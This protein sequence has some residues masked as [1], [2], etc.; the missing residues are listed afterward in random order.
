MSDR[1]MMFNQTHTK[2]FKNKYDGD[3]NSWA[4][5]D[6]EIKVAFMSDI[7]CGAEGKRFCTTIWDRDINDK[8]LLPREFI[9]RKMPPIFDDRKIKMKLS[10]LKNNRAKRDVFGA[11]NLEFKKLKAACMFIMQNRVSEY[12]ISKFNELE[13]EPNLC[14][15]WMQTQYGATS[16]GVF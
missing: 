11:L 3:K 6:T 14:Y 15:E 2:F 13:C 9:E 12:I 7:N 1:S 16:S 10:D 8:R 5:F 4:Q